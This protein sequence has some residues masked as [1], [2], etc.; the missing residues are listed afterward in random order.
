[1]LK[2]KKATTIEEIRKYCTPKPLAEEDL[3]QFYINTNKA[4]NLEEDIFN[5]LKNRVTAEVE[6]RIL[7]CGH[8]GCGKSTELNN[9]KK[10]LKQEMFCVSF[11]VHSEC[12]MFTLKAEELL[13]VI[14][15]RLVAS[16]KDAGLKIN[17]KSLQ[18]IYDYFAK[19]SRLEESE[20][21]AGI[22]AGGGVAADK[23][24]I[25]NLLGL[26]AY[27][28]TDIKLG[29][30][31]LQTTESVL[32]KRPSALLL[33]INQLIE[34]IKAG[35]PE[36]KKLLIIVEDLDKLNLAVA[37]DIFIN[38]CAFLKINAS[39][40]YTIPIFL[41][42][43]PDAQ[44]CRN[45]FD[46]DISLPMIKIKEIDG[47]ENNESFKIIKE[48]INARLDE[49]LIDDDALNMLIE[50]TGGVLRHCFEALQKASETNSALQEKK[51][52]AKQIEYGLNRLGDNLWRQ[53]APPYDPP[54]SGVVKIEELYKRLSDYYK[55][56]ESKEAIAPSPDVINQILLM[57]SALI[58]YINGEERF[59]VHPI[60]E[61]RIKKLKWYRE[62]VE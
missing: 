17:D 46:S 5:K 55:I 47:K 21:K 11:S 45:N 32:I 33:K 16:A 30:R 25:G 34:K 43:A 61:K 39:V 14:A 26:L 29:S 57:S 62:I 40:I 24:I 49:K 58:E 59:V 3:E 19:E 60:L 4:R 35:L 31:A 22:E 41:F 9:L 23:S 7:F 42:Y 44:A 38:N 27:I 28:K 6:N 15:E 20:I 1:M 50:K 54:P 52:G 37:R 56:E 13:L 18:D 48:I 51:L 8:K 2:L 12:N 36:G 53:V 10:K